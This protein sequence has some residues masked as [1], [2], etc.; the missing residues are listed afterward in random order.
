MAILETEFETI[1]CPLCG[2]REARPFVQAYDRRRVTASA[3]QLVCCAGCSL[4]YQNPRVRP[5]AIGKY[6][7]GDYH[8][9]RAGRREA[10]ARPVRREQRKRRIIEELGFRPGRVL[11]V[12]CANGDFLVAMRE[13]GWQVEGVEHSEEASA[14]G[15]DRHGLKVRAG[16]LVARP[17]DGTRF[18]LITMWAVLPHFPNPLETVRHAAGL[19]A[20]GGAL[21]LCVANI[22]SWA[23]KTRRGEWGH[24]DQPRHYC[25]FSP[26]TLERLFQASGL[27]R[28]ALRHDDSLWQS[29]MMVPPFGQLRRLIVRA[30][31]SRGRSALLKG[32][33]LLNRVLAL[34]VEMAARWSEQ[35]GMIITKAVRG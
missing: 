7:A 34:P 30:P 33:S 18:D 1:S 2:A 19:L 5:A 31:Q 15:R 6:Y 22:D 13:G 24:L 28:T 20:E 26:A 21:V 17:E 12:G 35:G 29:Q 4:V 10:A 8:K 3:F 25:M 11:D 16:E 23:F 14:Y 9:A 32:V 27:R